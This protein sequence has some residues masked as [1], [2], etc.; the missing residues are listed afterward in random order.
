MNSI[1]INFENENENETFPD[2]HKCYCCKLYKT[3]PEF[4][5]IKKTNKVFKVCQDCNRS[6]SSKYYHKNRLTILE[7]LK[8][9][10]IEHK[11]CCCGSDVQIRN[12]LNHTKTKK[13]INRLIAL[14]K[15]I[16]V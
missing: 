10:H 2:C 15:M 1:Q 4:L 14:N 7:G 9:Y 13:H 16:A 8:T 5:F 11:T 12:M 3:T 6:N